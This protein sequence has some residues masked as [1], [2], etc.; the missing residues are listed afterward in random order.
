VVRAPVPPAGRAPARP[1]RFAPPFAN[2]SL[3]RVRFAPPFANASL[4]G[5]RF[6][7]P[8]ANASLP[9]VQLFIPSMD[10]SLFWGRIDA[11]IRIE[12]LNFAKITLPIANEHRPPIQPAPS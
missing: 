3:F 4:P 7:L 12:A 9:G 8:F 5:V 2:A 11:S 10:E 6:A 1:L